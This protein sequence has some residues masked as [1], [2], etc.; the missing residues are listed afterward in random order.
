MNERTF[1]AASAHRLEDPQRL[2]WLPPGEAVSLLGLSAGMTIADVGAGTGFFALPFARAVAPSGVVHAVDLQPEMLAILEGKL[3]RDDAPA[4]ITL[5]EG[6]AAATG[7]PDQ[8]C[9]VAFLANVWHEVDDPA[10]VLTEMR[11]LLRP[12]GRVA[13]LDWRDDVSH[14]P[15]PPLHHR[16]GSAKATQQLRAAAWEDIECWHVGEFSYLLAGSPSA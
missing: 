3:H 2:L 1:Q 9:D 4:N 10:A 16:I 15:G 11:R 6:D 5:H 8:C 7:L 13:I 12:G 14:P